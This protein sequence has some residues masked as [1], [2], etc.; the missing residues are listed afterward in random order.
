M[1]LTLG[2]LQTTRSTISSTLLP[3]FCLGLSSQTNLVFIWH[4][5]LGWIGLLV[6]TLHFSLGTTLHC[7]RVTLLQTGTCKYAQWCFVEQLSSVALPLKDRFFLLKP[8]VLCMSMRQI[9]GHYRSACWSVM[10]IDLALTYIRHL[11]SIGPD[12]AP[13]SI[14]S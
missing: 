2:K 3:H 1:Y 13:S 9:Y 11:V 14:D 4:L 5:A 8:N 6:T 7:S 12:N 10:T